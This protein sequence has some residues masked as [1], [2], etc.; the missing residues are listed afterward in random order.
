MAK[1][2]D[3]PTYQS[4]PFTL[5]FESFGRFFNKNVGWAIALLVAATLGFFMQ[6]GSNVISSVST[7]STSRQSSIEDSITKDDSDRKL[8]SSEIVAIV[9][10]ISVFVLF[11]I[12]IFLVIG[13][14]LQGMFSY[15]ALQSELGKS[16][17]FNEAI[18]ATTGK[19][20]LLLGSQALAMLKIIG[21][22]MLFIIP[23]IFA[24]LRFALLPFV[25]MSGDKPVTKVKESHDRTKLLVKGRL[26][27]VFGVQTVAMIVPFVGELLGL[28]GK[29]ALHQQLQA[30]E[31]AEKPKPHWLNYL[32]FALIG[33]AVIL[34]AFITMLAVLLANAK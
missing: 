25:V 31:K 29:A 17:G 24:A 34:L 19:F 15:V 27:E 9:I 6:I 13:T 8:D 12:G 18:N 2:S 20:W 16:V 1:K 10:L 3:L 5:C 32:G 22:T 28:T 30:Y 33:L 21:W 26:I 11:M 7:T 4:N 14:F 23:G